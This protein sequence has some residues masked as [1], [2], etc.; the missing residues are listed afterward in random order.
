MMFFFVIKNQ[1]KNFY[2]DP[3]AA[4][5]TGFYEKKCPTRVEKKSDPDRLAGT[6][7]EI[8]LSRVD[9]LTRVGW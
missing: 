7:V 4:Q 8:F 9:I 2:I 6:W 1:K 5:S 3:S